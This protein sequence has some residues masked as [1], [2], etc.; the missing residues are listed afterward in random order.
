MNIVYLGNGQFGINCLNALT[1]SLHKLSLIITAT[2]QLAGRGRL[3]TP[4]AVSLWAKEKSPREA[5]TPSIPVLETD[6]VNAPDSIAQIKNAKPD[7]ILVISF[8][9]KIG[10]PLLQLPPKGTINVHASLLPKYRGAA[11][12]NW[13]IINGEKETGVS[14][15]RLSEKIDAGDIIAQTKIQIEPD[16]NAAHLHDR[17]AHLAAPLLLETIDLIETGKAV[18][19]KQDDSAAT[20]APKLKKTDGYIDFNE[21]AD[22]LHRKILG[23]FP[24]PGASANYLSKKTGK[25]ELVTFT[26]AKA[27]ASANPDNLVPGTIDENLN[28]ICG[29]NALIITRIK[30]AGSSI[31]NF[32]AFV[33]GRH[34]KSGDCFLKLQK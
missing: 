1:K 25:T 19:I 27:I 29:Q 9:Q 8:G 10:N 18:Y 34:T 13:V 23:L 14:I 15:I 28:V 7:L 3:L 11:P 5:G 21:P 33:N 32:T 31:M 2:P 16:E 22:L 4:T 26:D 24:W 17:L 20:K 30:P 12:V 6:D